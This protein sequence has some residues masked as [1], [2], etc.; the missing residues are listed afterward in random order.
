MG[1]FISVQGFI[2][3]ELPRMLWDAVSAHATLSTVSGTAVLSAIILVLMNVAS[4]VPTGLEA[5]SYRIQS[6]LG[7]IKERPKE[8]IEKWKWNGIVCP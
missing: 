1:I 8:S 6:G 2:A 3:T 7:S 5:V 4:N